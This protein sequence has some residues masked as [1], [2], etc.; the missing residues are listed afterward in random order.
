MSKEWKVYVHIVPKDITGYDNDKY[1]IGVTSRNPQERWGR[2]SKYKQHRA[3]YPAIEKYG[4]DNIKHVVILDNLSE[5]EAKECEKYLISKYRT[6]ERK[7]GY[8]ITVGGDGTKG[9]RT[10][11]GV[12]YDDKRKEKCRCGRRAY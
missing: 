7:Y 6:R 10:Q 4:W 3:F 1:Y 5:Q 9:A 12:K 2:G 11:K 8:N